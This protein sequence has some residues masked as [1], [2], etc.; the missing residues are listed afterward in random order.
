MLQYFKFVY[1]YLTSLAK[2]DII[3]LLD[4]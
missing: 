1:Y 4:L 3:V 2:F